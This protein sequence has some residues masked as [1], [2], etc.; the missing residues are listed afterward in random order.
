MDRDGEYTYV[1]CRSN[2]VIDYV[3]ANEGIKKTRKGICDRR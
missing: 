3:I 1:G 2:M